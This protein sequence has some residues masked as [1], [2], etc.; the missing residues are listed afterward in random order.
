LVNWKSTIEEHGP[1]VWSIAY[2]LLGNEADASDCF[3]E[4]FVTAVQTSRKKKIRN[5]E[6]FL[7]LIATQRGVDLL[8]KRRPNFRLY[9]TKDDC[10]TL[11][12]TEPPPQIKVQ[13]Q[14]LSE[15]L[16]TALAKIPQQEAEVFC[17]RILNEFSYRQIAKEMNLNENY[18]GVLINRARQKLQELLKNVVV[19]YG[20]EVA[21]E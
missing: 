19:E 12:S 15:Q 1:R 4:V 2:R 3:Q 11:E 6:A 5:M 17:L 7:S 9:R 8:R 20:R 21:H 16:R 10:Q 14:E 13:W 18:V